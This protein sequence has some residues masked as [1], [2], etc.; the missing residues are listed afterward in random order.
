MDIT[1][2]GFNE[3]DTYWFSLSESCESPVTSITSMNATQ[4]TVSFT[5]SSTSAYHLCYQLAFEQF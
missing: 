5:Q 2:Y 3:E 4:M 1:I